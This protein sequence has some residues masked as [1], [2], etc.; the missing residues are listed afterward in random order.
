MKILTDEEMLKAYTTATGKR[1]S[2][3]ESERAAFLKSHRA[4]EAKLME[5]IGEPV[6]F[7]SEADDMI[8]GAQTGGFT[9]PL[10]AIKGVE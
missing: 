1:I 5:R 6:T 9:T 10:F 3:N 7:Y 8:N 2:N 4:I